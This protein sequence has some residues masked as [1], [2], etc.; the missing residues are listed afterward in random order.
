MCFAYPRPLQEELIKIIKSK[1]YGGILKDE[2]ISAIK[3]P[4]SNSIF[5]LLPDLLRFSVWF[6]PLQPVLF[7]AFFQPGVL[8]GRRGAVVAV[9]F[10]FYGFACQWSFG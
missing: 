6:T 2:N 9:P 7:P 5:R 4:G 3:S 1:N 8:C 10:L